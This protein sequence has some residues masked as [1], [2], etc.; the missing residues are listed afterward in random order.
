IPVH[1]IKLLCVTSE[2][3][4][5][6]IIDNTLKF[7]EH[8]IEKTKKANSM[9]EIIRNSFQFLNTVQRLLSHFINC[10]LTLQAQFGDPYT[11][12]MTD[13]IESVQRRATRQLSR[14]KDLAY[15]D[16]LRKL[17][18]PSLKY[19]LLRTDMI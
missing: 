10:I 18:L 8:I 4:I 14:M 15:P 19:K 16:R 11:K 13:K 12:N 5:G 2:N 1:Q 17:K 9:M 3:D 6:V 7:K